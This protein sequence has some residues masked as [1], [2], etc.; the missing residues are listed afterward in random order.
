MAAFYFK[1]LKPLNLDIGSN[2]SITTILKKQNKHSMVQKEV[3]NFR[4]ELIKSPGSRGAAEGPGLPLPVHGPPHPQRFLPTAASVTTYHISI[5]TSRLQSELH[6][7]GDP[8]AL[9]SKGAHQ[10]HFTTRIMRKR[11][12]SASQRCGF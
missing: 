3:V 4:G 7:L 6:I 10:A 12:K 9:H 11:M 5:P 2:G 8:G 1:V